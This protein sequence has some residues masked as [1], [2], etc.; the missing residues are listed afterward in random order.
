MMK[1][2]LYTLLAAAA[3]TASAA[4]AQQV[5]ELTAPTQWE[6]IRSEHLQMGGTHPT[7]A[8]SP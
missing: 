7:A 6:P 3:L 5:Y 4:H 1:T 2:K 8:A